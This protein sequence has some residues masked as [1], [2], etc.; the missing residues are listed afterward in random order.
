MIAQKKTETIG[1]VDTPVLKVLA[2]N[3]TRTWVGTEDALNAAIANG[4]IKPG[5]VA[6]TYVDAQDLKE[7][8]NLDYSTEEKDTGMKWIDGK[9]IYRKV[10]STNI[11]V[12]TGQTEGAFPG[13]LIS[14]LSTVVNLYGY[15]LA[16]NNFYYPLNYYQNDAESKAFTTYR[17]LQGV[18]T[19]TSFFRLVDRPAYCV[20]EYTKS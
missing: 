1:G 12:P 18:V 6:D 3:G 11:L 2:S 5:T 9:P 17:P 8:Y 10:F 4:E 14:G 19:V 13:S 15:I 7:D 16:N 20:L